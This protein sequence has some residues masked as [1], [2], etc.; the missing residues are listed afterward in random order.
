MVGW[1]VDMPL[2]NGGRKRRGSA[3]SGAGVLYM[4]AL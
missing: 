4:V 1:R 3:K 2:E